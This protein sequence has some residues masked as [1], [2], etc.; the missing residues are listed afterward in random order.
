[1]VIKA[2]GGYA[3]AK[4][5]HHHVPDHDC[6]SWGLGE[7]FL[8]RNKVMAHQLWQ[9]RG[10]GFTQVGIPGSA[11]VAR[12]VLE[13]RVHACALEPARKSRAII[14]GEVRV[15][16]KG[17]VADD[18]ETAAVDVNDRCEIHRDAVRA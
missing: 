3:I 4:P 1:M 17:A 18:F 5:W 16:G 10:N 14:S 6:C 2:G 12:V 13:H 11:A 7:S 15:L 9:R 8:E